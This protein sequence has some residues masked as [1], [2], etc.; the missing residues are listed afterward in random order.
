MRASHFGG[1]HLTETQVRL[2]F[3][4][5]L[6]CSLPSL[7]SLILHFFPCSFPCS[8]S[9]SGN[10]PCEKDS[11]PILTWLEGLLSSLEC[12]CQPKPPTSACALRE[13]EQ[14]HA[15]AKWGDTAQLPC[16]PSPS[17]AAGSCSYLLPPAPKDG[18]KAS[19]KTG[20][21]AI[22]DTRAPFLQETV[23]HGWAGPLYMAWLGMTFGGRLSHSLSLG[24]GTHST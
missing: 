3:R 12:D 18:A 23:P 10:D 19:E 8:P 11:E 17:L 2:L 4:F 9:W 22:T 13:R 15:L 16:S 24:N 1:K 7:S 20:D 14:G 21:P 6:F 5:L